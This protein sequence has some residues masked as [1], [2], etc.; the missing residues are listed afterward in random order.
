[1]RIPSKSWHAPKRPPLIALLK[2]QLLLE[3]ECHSLGTHVKH[4][5]YFLVRAV[6]LEASKKC[7]QFEW[8]GRMQCM[9][10]ALGYGIS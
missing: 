5:A 2:L 8:K 6:V 4:I 7:H 9:I 3:G 1:M 10:M